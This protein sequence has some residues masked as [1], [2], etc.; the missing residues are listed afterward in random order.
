MHIGSSA[1]WKMHL[2]SKCR[3]SQR[4]W[5]WFLWWPSRQIQFSQV[6][7]VK[8]SITF[9]IFPMEF[10]RNVELHFESV[11]LWSFTETWSDTTWPSHREKTDPVT[12]EPHRWN[13]GQPSVVTI[14]NSTWSARTVRERFA[15]FFMLTAVSPEY[16]FYFPTLLFGSLPQSQYKSLTF[17]HSTVHWR[18]RAVFHPSI[19][20]TSVSPFSPFAANTICQPSPFV[21]D[22]ILLQPLG[23][24]SIFS[25]L[26][27]L[28]LCLND[29]KNWKQQIVLRMQEQYHTGTK[30]ILVQSGNGPFL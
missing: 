6:F 15:S 5:E 9:W 12:W 21:R 17:K 19:F 4:P 7:C 16:V 14:L 26:T 23:I 18:T 3:Y 22:Q 29:D 25:F 28:T 20:T 10:Q 13:T 11:P 2:T 30:V 24:E 8:W 27:H 1:I